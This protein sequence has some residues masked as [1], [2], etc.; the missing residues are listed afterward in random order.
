MITDL[1]ARLMQVVRVWVSSCA[2]TGLLVAQP[3]L[4]ITSPTDGTV[5]HPGESLTVTVEALPA[6]AFKQVIIVGWDPIGFSRPLT[7]PPYRFTIQVPSKID[8]GK[9]LLTADGATAPGQGT[10][11]DPIAIVVERPD[12][13]VRLRI[14]PSILDVSLSQKGYLRVV[15]EFAYGENTDL[16]KSRRIAYVSSA[17]AVA[18]VQTQGIVT[19]IAPGSARVIVTYGELEVEVPVMVTGNKR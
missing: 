15:G 16:T 19:P 5:V 4:R 14:E 11:S 8:P 10:M 18:T 1:T 12:P 9:Y 7:T 6:G 3:S 13:P 17:P 2:L